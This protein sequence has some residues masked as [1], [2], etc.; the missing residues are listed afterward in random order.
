M[1]W[2]KH[3]KSRKVKLHC[4]QAKEG[5]WFYSIADINSY[6]CIYQFNSISPKL[7]NEM[8]PAIRGN[9][10]YECS[11]TQIYGYILSSLSLPFYIS[12]IRELSQYPHT[13]MWVMV[14]IVINQP[15]GV[16]ISLTQNCF[17]PTHII[18]RKHYSF[19]SHQGMARIAWHK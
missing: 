16:R 9:N 13:N 18:L 10:K 7:S 12:G 11:Y 17:F 4:H 6:K 15:Y 8:V 14:K 19:R 2:I 1:R 5:E 3:G